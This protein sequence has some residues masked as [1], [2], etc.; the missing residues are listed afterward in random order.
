MG[1]TVEVVL[2]KWNTNLDEDLLKTWDATVL[3]K[4][5]KKDAN[6]RGIPV[7]AGHY[8]VEFDDRRNSI[9]P[10]LGSPPSGLKRGDTVYVIK[11]KFEPGYGTVKLEKKLSEKNGTEFAFLRYI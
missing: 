4:P 10:A 1:D 9:G 3:K 8:V 2:S 6:F 5:I 7:P 11:D